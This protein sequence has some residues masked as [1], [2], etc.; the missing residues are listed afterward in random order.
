MKHSLIK[1]HAL[2]LVILAALWL[3]LSLTPCY[4]QIDTTYY[5]FVMHKLEGEDFW[6]TFYDFPKLRPGVYRFQI[7]IDSTPPFHNGPPQWYALHREF[8]FV[9]DPQGGVKVNSQ[10]PL[11][12]KQA[13]LPR[14]EEANN[15]KNARKDQLQ[16][17][18][19]Y[20]KNEQRLGFP[21]PNLM[22][23]LLLKNAVQ[24]SWQL[25]DKTYRLYRMHYF[26]A[27]SLL[28]EEYKSALS[29]F[30]NPSEVA[31][32]DFKQLKK[33]VDS[34]D[35]F[36]LAQYVESPGEK[37]QAFYGHFQTWF[38]QWFDIYEIPSP[39]SN[40]SSFTWYYWILL[41][42]VIAIILFFVASSFGFMLPEKLRQIRRHFRQHD[43]HS[44]SFLSDKPVSSQHYIPRS[45]EKRAAAKT[46]APVSPASVSKEDFD[47][48]R[49][50]FEQ[51]R[52]MQERQLKRNEL[53]KEKVI[54]IVKDEFFSQSHQ[55]ETQS[56]TPEQLLIRDTNEPSFKKWENKP[57]NT[58][59]TH[60][61]ERTLI[62][63][64][65]IQ[66]ALEKHL[67]EIL[68]QQMSM[69]Y[70]SQDFSDL[71]KNQVERYL[72][73]TFKKELEKQLLRYAQSYW[74]QY[75]KDKK[76]KTPQ[77]AETKAK[78]KKGE[79]TTPPAPSSSSTY[80]VKEIKALL[81]SMKAVD[82]AALNRLDT[83]VEPCI[84]MTNMV[85]NCLKLNQPI[86]Q[87]Q[88]LSNAIEKLTSGKI[89]LLIP[90]V[91]DEILEEENN[92]VGHQTVTNGVLDVVATLI[93]PGVK[94]DKIVRRK[95][96]VIQNK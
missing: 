71:V 19:Q 80:N 53:S 96:D 78:N 40:Q 62:P 88:Q 41:V 93:R 82:E 20:M 23:F 87:Y 22:R 46:T 42:L 27:G 10:H 61:F 83:S 3:G 75:L 16:P 36:T 11:D 4:A 1:H 45:G 67:P 15:W 9:T 77:A 34:Q 79:Q 66:Q 13:N 8:Q 69:L 56:S 90:N 57:D 6:K 2:Q 72:N 55:L 33:W 85:S 30:I 7:V 63:V 35:S 91:G 70:Q 24:E 95:A 59:E 21:D 28:D 47:S 32:T 84:F 51:F 68:S 5:A 60:I 86:T 43:E 50:E 58:K 29:R 39:A 26:N 76:S 44:A 17:L 48:L 81:L 94:C 37:H 25:G 73:D 12:E 64:E 38:N 54:N 18:I 92:V 14:S 49:D 52:A 31:S 65:D 89:T 74:H